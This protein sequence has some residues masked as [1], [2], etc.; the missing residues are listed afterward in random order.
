EQ[1]AT[2]VISD[3]IKPAVKTLTGVIDPG[4]DTAELVNRCFRNLLYLLAVRHI[5]C[6]GYGVPATRSNPLGDVAERRFAA[7]GQYECDTLFGRRLGRGQA[8]ARTRARDNHDLLIQL[9][10]IRRHID[11]GSD[12]SSLSGTATEEVSWV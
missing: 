3:L 9:F 8:D 12:L 7:G 6:N 2:V 4:I 5:T 1:S 10:Q 11:S